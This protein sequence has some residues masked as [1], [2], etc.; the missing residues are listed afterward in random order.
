MYD[1]NDAR[2]NST[3]LDAL[4]AS[5]NELAATI[6]CEKI[7]TKKEV[8]TP[9]VSPYNQVQ[10][11]SLSPSLQPHQPIQMPNGAVEISNTFTQLTKASSQQPSTTNETISSCRT[12]DIETF[13]SPDSAPVETFDSKL[14]VKQCVASLN[15]AAAPHNFSAVTITTVLRTTKI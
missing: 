2:T 3:N 13:A 6:D 7:D 1:E 12:N 10:Y 8:V 14:S 15:S 9:A 5:V 11:P 4:S